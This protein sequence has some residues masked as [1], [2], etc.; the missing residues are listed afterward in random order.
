MAEAARSTM[1]SD[2]AVQAKTGRTWP[3][4]FRLLD[5]AGLKAATH[6]EIVAAVSAN[7]ASGWW[8]QQVTVEY[9]RARGLR[10]VHQKT[11]GYS[12][13]VSKTIAVPLAALYRAAAD[14]K[15]RKPWFPPLAF[16]PS[17]QTEDKSLR[18]PLEGG[19][20]RL[21]VNFY[22]K[23]AGKAQITVQVNK[24]A[25]ADAAEHQRGLWRDALDRLKTRLER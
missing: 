5:D 12:I 10:A 1:T 20:A 18:G 23:N 7:G 19:P 11:D 9:E 21:E 4:W 22:A 16:T 8:A 25:D 13:S 17:S 15:A 24:L 3:E 2:A 14:A 6:K